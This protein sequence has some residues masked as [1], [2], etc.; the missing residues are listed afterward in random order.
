MLTIGSRRFINLR[1]ATRL[2]K[3]TRKRS[4]RQHQPAM[5]HG[6]VGARSVATAFAEDARVQRLAT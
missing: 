4:I 5:V 1:L 6:R 2:P 3:I